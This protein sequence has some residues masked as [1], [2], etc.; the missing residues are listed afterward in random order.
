M[1]HIA[2][3]ELPCEYFFD[4]LGDHFKLTDSSM[5]I[6][7]L[8][9]VAWMYLIPKWL[10]YKIRTEILEID[11]NGAN[12]HRLVQVPLAE[13]EKWDAEHDDAGQLRQRRTAGSESSQ[14]EQILQ[15]PKV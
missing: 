12:T 13:L 15:R 7:G 5:I 4:A 2:L 9:Y 3:W 11:D 1:Q 6:C 8:Y 10:G 14:E